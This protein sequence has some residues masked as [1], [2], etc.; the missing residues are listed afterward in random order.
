MG[1]FSR[2]KKYELNVIWKRKSVIS[3]A[4]QMKLIAIILYI[5]EY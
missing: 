3:I 4:Y 2:E 1:I 5:F